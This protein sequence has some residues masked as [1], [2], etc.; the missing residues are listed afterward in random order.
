MKQNK[1]VLNLIN[2]Q[3]KT[4]NEIKRSELFIFAVTS[5]LFNLSLVIGAIIMISNI[6]KNGCL[7]LWLR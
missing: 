5:F 7:P 3:R 6:D 2:K 4:K 1:E